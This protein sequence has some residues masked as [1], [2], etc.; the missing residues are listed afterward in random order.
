MADG[1]ALDLEALVSR[2]WLFFGSCSSAVLKTS[3]GVDWPVGG[4]LELSATQ[5]PSDEVEERSSLRM[6]S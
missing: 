1:S 6:T 2:D 3:F 4:E 5:S